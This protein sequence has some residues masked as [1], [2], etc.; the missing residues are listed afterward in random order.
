[1]KNGL[2]KILTEPSHI[3]R[4]NGVQ[5]TEDDLIPFF[6]SAYTHPSSIYKDKLFVNFMKT[7]LLQL[8]QVK[9]VDSSKS[10]E[11]EVS[12]AE[13]EVVEDSEFC[14]IIAFFVCV[15]Q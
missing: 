14:I 5:R 10:K 4:E 9:Q 15:S 8:H 3:F 2:F 11:A 12:N 1:M 13:E 6:V 7:I